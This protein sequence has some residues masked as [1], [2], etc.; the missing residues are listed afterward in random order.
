M[1]WEMPA[2]GGLAYAFVE[3]QIA[4]M[5]RYRLWELVWVVYSITTSLAVAYIGLAAPAITGE[6]GDKRSEPT[7][8]AC[9]SALRVTLREVGR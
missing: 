5:R 9:S 6:Q 4:L 2:Q 8:I 7:E 1:I 3:R